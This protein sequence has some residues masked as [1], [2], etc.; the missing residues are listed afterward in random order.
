MLSAWK[1]TYFISYRFSWADN[2]KYII[3]QVTQKSSTE[4]VPF[5][6]VQDLIFSVS[7]DVGDVWFTKTVSVE[8]RNLVLHT[9]DRLLPLFVICFAFQPE[10]WRNCPYSQRLPFRITAM[11]LTSVVSTIWESRA[12]QFTRATLRGFRWELCLILC[13][14]KGARLAPPANTSRWGLWWITLIWN[15]LEIVFYDLRFS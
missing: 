11:I 8:F 3:I 14:M 5:S 1:N 2:A 10:N 6:L 13:F 15:S 9:F 7:F 12:H 4:I